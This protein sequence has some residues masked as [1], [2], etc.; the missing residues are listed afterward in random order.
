MKLNCSCIYLK[1]SFSIHHIIKNSQLEVVEDLGFNYNDD[2]VLSDWKTGK[3]AIDE[4][5]RGF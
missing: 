4:S 1:Q 5:S 3:G 2:K